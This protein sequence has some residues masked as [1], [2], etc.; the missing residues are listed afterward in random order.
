[1]Q[2]IKLVYLCHGWMLGLHGRP[3]IWEQVEAWQFGPVIRDLYDAVR[4]YKGEPVP[5]LL[6]PH[7]TPKLEW[8]EEDL[9]GQVYELYG[10]DSGLALSRL[11]H[12]DGT[13]WSITWEQFGQNSI[14]S[15]DL[16]RD[17]FAGLAH[18]RSA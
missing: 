6:P 2:L 11:T 7:Q 16:I 15:N 8:T 14:I 3:L 18:A 10:Q 17:H 4:H 5:E 12:A 9:I 13:P 1:M